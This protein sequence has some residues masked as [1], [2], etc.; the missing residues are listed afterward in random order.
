MYT[1]EGLQP[2]TNYV[3]LLR[4]ENPEGLSPAAPMSEI[5]RTRPAYRTSDIDEVD[6]EE[7]RSQL[8][9]SDIQLISSEPA[10]STSIRNTWKVSMDF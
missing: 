10:S 1:V 6:E 5:M 7:V 9:T 4:A 8:S 2:D 3:F